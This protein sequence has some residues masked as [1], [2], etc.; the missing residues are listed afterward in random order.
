MRLGCAK[1]LRVS[2][3]RRGKDL[4]ARL[5]TICGVTMLSAQT[6]LADYLLTPLSGGANSLTVQWGAS[7]TLE[8]ELTSNANDQHNSAIT[9]VLFT[10]PGLVYESYTW[11]AP[12]TDDPL[13]DDS[14]PGFTVL[15][16][17]IDADAFIDPL[18][19]TLIDIELSNVVIGSTFGTGTLAT[20]TLSVPDN[21]GFV[22]SIFIVAQPDTFAN[23][24]DE[25][26]T[27]GGPLFELEIIPEPA[28]ML[29]LLLG[30]VAQR[31]SR[32]PMGRG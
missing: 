25:I 2:D 27:T 9:E 20:L 14:T 22:G 1:V 12:Y 6:G 31:R 13:Y 15:P 28:G 24:F 32:I 18:N 4:L 19:P 3:S 16:T 29:L 11:G 26:R 30:L 10:E 8:L 23:G 7:F 21:F 5:I 17:V